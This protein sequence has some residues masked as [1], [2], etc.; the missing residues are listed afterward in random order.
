MADTLLSVYKIAIDNDLP[1]S[2][3][4]GLKRDLREFKGLQRDVYQ[5]TH[6]LALLG[7]AN[8]QGGGQGGGYRGGYGGGQG[9][10]YGGGQGGSYGGG[11]GGS[12]GGGQGGGYRGSQ[13]GGYRGGQGG[14]YRGSFI[15]E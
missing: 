15:T 6:N 14:I 1:N 11:Q 5:P 10:G 9:G 7:G 2:L 4:R 13:G 3:I 8:N 12:Y